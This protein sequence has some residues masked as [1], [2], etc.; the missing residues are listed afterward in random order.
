MAELVAKK[1]AEALFEVA[2]DL[3]SVEQVKENFAYVSTFLKENPKVKVL[4]EHPD[5]DIDEKKEVLASFALLQLL[6]VLV[7]KGNEGSISSIRARFDA[8]SD[9]QRGMAVGEVITAVPISEEELNKLEASL[10]EKM[11]KIVK[12]TNKVDESILGGVKVRIGDKVFDSS[13]QHQLNTIS[14]DLSTT[15]GKKEEVKNS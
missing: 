4:L 10:S 7:E 1:Y 5:L 6:N 13:V 3:D 11:N 15:A 9:E 2:S 8:I 12:L 14:R